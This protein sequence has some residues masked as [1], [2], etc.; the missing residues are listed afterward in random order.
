MHVLAASI[1]IGIVA[2]FAA[3]GGV[4]NRMSATGGGALELDALLS[5]WP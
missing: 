2:S 4:L 5:F 1:L 3:V